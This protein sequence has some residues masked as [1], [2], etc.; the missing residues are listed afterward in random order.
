MLIENRFAYLLLCPELYKLYFLK[1]YFK[2]IWM[3]KTEY[4]ISAS[5]PADKDEALHFCYEINIKYWI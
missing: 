2:Q 3:P 1:I 4:P 5:P